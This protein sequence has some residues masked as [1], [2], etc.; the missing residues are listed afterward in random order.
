[1]V[2]QYISYKDKREE[3]Y[4]PSA[5]GTPR[6]RTR[7]DQVPP[8]RSKF[9]QTPSYIQVLGSSWFLPKAVSSV[10][11]SKRLTWPI[12][13]LF[14][15]LGQ[16]SAHF[17]AVSIFRCCYF[18]IL[19]YMK[20]IPFDTYL[21]FLYIVLFSFGVTLWQKM[22]Y[23]LYVFPTIVLLSVLTNL[24]SV[25][26]HIIKTTSYTI[27]VYPFFSYHCYTLLTSFTPMYHFVCV[28]IFVP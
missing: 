25:L 20:L 1:M 18:L 4:E 6:E 19:F 9:Q 2:F 26:M 23:I 5:W 7:D 10:Y 16:L 13:I 21:A 8:Y 27:S 12:V 14:G 22:F 17:K 11:L 15:I 28:S 24:F 3:D